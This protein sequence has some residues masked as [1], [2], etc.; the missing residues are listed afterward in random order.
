MAGAAHISSKGE[1]GEQGSRLP[2]GDEAPQAV[3]VS[4]QSKG[5]QRG[6]ENKREK[7]CEASEPAGARGS[8]ARAWAE[9]QRN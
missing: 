8:W 3:T 9:G 4:P 2:K 7:K 6:L 1:D 5:A